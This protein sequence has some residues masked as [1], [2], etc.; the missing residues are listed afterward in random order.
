MGG[1][2][3][4]RRR[5]SK[6]RRGWVEGGLRVGRRWV[7]G[8]RGRVVSGARISRGVGGGA[9]RVRPDEAWAR[10][11]LEDEN[12]RS[13]IH[14]GYAPRDSLRPLWPLAL[15]H[16]SEQSSP[17]SLPNSFLPPARTE[18][19][20]PPLPPPWGPQDGPSVP[21]QSSSRLPLGVLGPE[22]GPHGCS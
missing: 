17:L 1:S 6:A 21:R 8:G 9:G 14:F 10:V 20:P 15:T 7:A 11:R 22:L 5:G 18:S 2:R 19:C 13:R 16:V 3:E 4:G 12:P